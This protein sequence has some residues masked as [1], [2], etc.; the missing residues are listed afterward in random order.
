VKAVVLVGGEGTRLR[1]LTLTTPKQMLPIVGVPMIQRVLAHLAAHSIDE[2]VLSL[3]YLPD[4]FVSAY[5]DSTVAGVRL[6][7]AVESEPLDTAGATRFAAK[8]A[9]FSETIVVVNGDV[10]T[11][12][13]ISALVAFHKS[14]G[15]E[16]SIG[17][18]PVA[19]PSP[20]GV[21]VTDPTGRVSE[22]VEKPPRDKA[23]SNE[24]NAGIYVLERSALERIN[25]TGRVSI[26]RETFPAIVRDRGLFALCDDSY[27]LDTGTP[28]A[29]VQANLDI[30]DGKRGEPPV[31]GAV[32]S[33]NGVWMSGTPVVEG[34]VKGP[35]WI[36]D[37]S[38]IAAGA[39]V[40]RSIIGPG[41]VVEPGAMVAESVL[42]DRAR[43]AADS[44]VRGSVLGAGSTVGERCAIGPTSVLGEDAVVASGTVLDGGRV[45]E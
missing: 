28:S 6:S 7:Y 22:F 33:G 26:E 14:R 4:A 37:G 42:L 35:C 20:F 29:F 1:P 36:G 41:C 38:Q 34:E 17:L 45:P 23:P 27:W 10:L 16:A 13:D 3:G 25:P 12:F 31:P 44:T 32:R 8:S 19:D 24:I 2:A 43:V 40:E 9:G 21:V 30:I 11:D 5:P 15:A 18:Y 39:R